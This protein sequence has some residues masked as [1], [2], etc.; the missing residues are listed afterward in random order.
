ME[1]WDPFVF[2]PALAMERV[3]APPCFKVKFSSANLVP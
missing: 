3:P 1:N 2:G